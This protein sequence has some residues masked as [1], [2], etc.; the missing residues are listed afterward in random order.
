MRF[1]AQEASTG[2]AEDKF[3]AVAFE[4]HF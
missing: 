4:F 3:D 2:I 1:S